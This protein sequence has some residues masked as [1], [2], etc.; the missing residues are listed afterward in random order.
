MKKL[1]FISISIGDKKSSKFRVISV[2]ANNSEKCSINTIQAKEVIE[3]NKDITFYI[4]L[5]KSNNFFRF[6]FNWIFKRKIKLSLHTK[7]SNEGYEWREF[8]SSNNHF[9]LNYFREK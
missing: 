9:S 7:E 5:G 8:S 4:Q 1:C 6:F 3:N 2:K